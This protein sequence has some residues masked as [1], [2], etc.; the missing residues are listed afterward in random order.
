MTHARTIGIVAL[1]SVTVIAAPVGTFYSCMHLKERQ[2]INDADPAFRPLLHLRCQ[3]WSQPIAFHRYCRYV[4][5]FPPDCDLSDA[6]VA[7]L[8]SLNRLPAENTLDVTIHTRTITDEALPHLKAIDTFDLLDVTGTSI[9][10]A[11]I[12][13]L[14]K[15]RPDAIVPTRNSQ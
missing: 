6:T 10:D 2:R 9:S 7:E 1:I 12:Q 3:V 13:Q 5:E 11:G 8:R 15:T 4:V 14:R